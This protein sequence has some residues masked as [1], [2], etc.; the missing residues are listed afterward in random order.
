MFKKLMRRGLYNRLV[1]KGVDQLL[2][3]ELAN[4]VYPGSDP[5][6]SKPPIV[7]PNE[8]AGIVEAF[9]DRNAITE[10]RMIALIWGS[11]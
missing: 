2:A 10:K 4:A 11:G 9:L 5:T 8:A 6:V 1:A 3:Y 7:G